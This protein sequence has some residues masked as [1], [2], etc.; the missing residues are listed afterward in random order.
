M[1]EKKRGLFSFALLAMVATHAL[2]HAAGN[3]RSTMIVELRE[4]FVLSN[5]EI[6]LISAIP[7]LASVIFTIP[8]GWMSDRYGARRLVG[9]SLAMAVFGALIAGL[10]INPAMYI[11]GLILL[12][13]T[14]TF[15][16]PPS[17]SYTARMVES[18]DRSKAMGFL[19]AGG[20]FGV[21]L[22]PASITLL[23]GYFMFQWRQVYLFWVPII[24]LGLVLVFFIKDMKGAGTE[25]ADKEP[26]EGEVQTLLNKDFVMYLSASGI[27]QFAL[28]MIGT[29]LPIYLADMR[30]W[31]VM[32]LGIMFSAASVLGLAASPVGGY[33]A[34]R[35][36]DKRWAVI[37][38]GVG[39]IFYI[40]AFF[41]EGFLPFMVLYLMYRF[42]GILGMPATAALTAKLSPP[43]QM[44]MGFAISFLPQSIV[45]VVAPLVAA[46]IA[47]YFGLFPIFTV[48]FIIMFLGLAVLQFGVKVE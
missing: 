45:S 40:V 46:Y 12:T 14:S 43:R 5:L 17:H 32:D 23:M 16:H 21:A 38:L 6:G 42:C 3:M 24:A 28:G 15:Y 22:G 36:G 10:T 26:E 11:V 4:E 41:T 27:R 20:T 47:D 35:L 39:Y 13:L 48:S 7:S 31:S 2:I 25:N 37:A 34:G 1:G 9:L 44:G 29:F 19:N 8:V 30:G 33:M 18:K